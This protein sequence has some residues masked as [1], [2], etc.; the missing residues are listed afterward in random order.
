MISEAFG[1]R[2]TAANGTTGSDLEPFGDAFLME[3]MGARTEG[4][5]QRSM[6]VQTD[7][8]ETY[9]TR[10]VAKLGSSVRDASNRTHTR[11]HRRR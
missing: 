4:G 10:F 7:R 6:N 3:A 11:T 2:L 5:L 8:I 9:R 1:R